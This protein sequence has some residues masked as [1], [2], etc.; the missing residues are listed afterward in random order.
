MSILDLNKIRNDFPILG[1]KVYNK[2]LVYFDNG[3]TTQKPTQVIDLVNKYH[4]ELN[5]SIHRGI[6][7]L[8]DLATNA[9]EDARKTVKNFIGAEKESEIIF[10]SGSTGSINLVA[11][12]FGEQFVPISFPGRCFAKE[13]KP[14]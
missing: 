9:Y 5:S 14:S 11:F 12:S 13:R 4:T 10:T 7:T 2:P 8:S 6:H 1:T 3:A